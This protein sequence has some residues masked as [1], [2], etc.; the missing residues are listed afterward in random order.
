MKTLRG[1]RALVTGAASGIGRAIAQQLAMQATHICLVDRDEETLQKTASDLSNYGVEVTTRVR[2][3]TD[4]SQ[5]DD[6][7]DS[8]LSQWGHVDLLVNN[9]GVCFYGTIENTPEEVWDQVLAV[10]LHAPIR[11]TRRLLGVLKERPEAHILNV[12]SMYG[13]VASNRCAAYHASKFG[14]VGFTEALRAECGRTSVGVTALCP[15]FVNT[16]LFTALADESHS[17]ARLPPKLVCTSPEKVAAKAIKAI[18]RNRGL[19]LVTP[20]AHAA[21][22]AKRLSPSLLPNLYGIGKRRKKI[23]RH[24]ENT[25]Q[26]VIL[27]MQAAEPMSQQTT[28]ENADSRKAA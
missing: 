1:K 27:P 21:F 16:G 28:H 10:N 6:C 26:P 5:I 19:A 20:L 3:V 17:P 11:F 24:V 7:V 14:L 4:E 15:G 12:A 9:A 8:I 13:L 25:D 23:Q 2:D 18:R 22:V